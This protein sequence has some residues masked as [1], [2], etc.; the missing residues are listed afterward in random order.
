MPCISRTDQRTL[1]SYSC[2][3]HARFLIGHIQSSNYW[4]SPAWWVCGSCKEG[5]KLPITNGNWSRDGINF[6]WPERP[7]TRQTSTPLFQVLTKGSKQEVPYLPLC[8][9]R[10]SKGVERKKK[11]SKLIRF[12]KNLNFHSKQDLAVSSGIKL[13]SEKRY[14]ESSRKGP[15]FIGRVQ[16]NPAIW[17]LYLVK[18]SSC[19]FSTKLSAARYTRFC[20]PA[21][22]KRNPLQTWHKV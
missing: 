9:R 18:P 4:V 17:P 13:L 2:L 11:K 3:P 20:E 8:V 14:R 22:W 21:I 7:G 16:I 1:L 12:Y 15:S 19:R 6:L 5:F 10:L